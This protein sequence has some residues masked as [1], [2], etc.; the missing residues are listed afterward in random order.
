EGIR[1]GEQRLAIEAKEPPRE[2]QQTRYSYALRYERS[3]PLACVDSCAVQRQQSAHQQLPGSSRQHVV[4]ERRR[5]KRSVLSE[6]KGS[7]SND[8]HAAEQLSTPADPPAQH[9]QH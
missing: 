9:E 6:R 3:L 2:Q 1:P 5:R 4:G 7:R 8:D